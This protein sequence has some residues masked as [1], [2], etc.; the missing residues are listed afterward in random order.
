MPSGPRVRPQPYPG[1]WRPRAGPAA[2]SKP[3]SE[4]ML[5]P[6]CTLVPLPRTP[7]S[8]PTAL[9]TNRQRVYTQPRTSVSE[10][11]RLATS[12]RRSVSAPRAAVV[13]RLPQFM[14][15]DQRPQFPPQT[16]PPSLFSVFRGPR[17]GA[18][19]FRIRT[20]AGFPGGTVP[21]SPISRRPRK[22]G[23]LGLTSFAGV[24]SDDALDTPLDALAPETRFRYRNPSAR[25]PFSQGCLMPGI[26][27]LSSV[28]QY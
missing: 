12:L 20:R 13:H 6:W 17:L 1:W 5:L 3:A 2:S 28:S 23:G 8:R 16:P 26:R 25:H 18:R 11:R 19:R 27:C 21:L 22:G 10:R 14:G 9:A 15:G 4:D 24:L 7:P